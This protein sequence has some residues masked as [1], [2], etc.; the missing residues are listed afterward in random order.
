MDHK[1]KIQV[2]QI[3]SRKIFNSLWF[4]RIFTIH[5]DSKIL[6][7]KKIVK[8]RIARICSNANHS[9]AVNYTLEESKPYM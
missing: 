8:E 2:V 1:K 9:N 5:K 4:V 3:K 6:M 7:I